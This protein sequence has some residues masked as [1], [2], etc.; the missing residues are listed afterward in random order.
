MKVKIRPHN[1]P[2]AQRGELERA[3]REYIAQEL[4]AYSK[5]LQWMLTRRMVYAV[6]LAL[7]DQYGFGSKRCQRVV[8]GAVEIITGVSEDVY[9]KGEID[10]DGVDK[11]ADNMLAELADRGIKI[12]IEGDDLY[13]DTEKIDK[14]KERESAL[15]AGTHEDAKVITQ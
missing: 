6:C 5:K 10:P 13:D 4:E 15:G 14:R 2:A 1:L 11:A 12:V 9:R 3:A 7:S 8:E